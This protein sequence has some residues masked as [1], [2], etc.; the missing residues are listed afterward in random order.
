MRNAL[1]RVDLFFAH[2]PEARRLVLELGLPVDRLRNGVAPIAGLEARPRAGLPAPRIVFAGRLHPEKGPDLLIR[3]LA[4]MERPPPTLM[5]GSGDMEDELRR[6]VGNAGLGRV[7]RFMGWRPDPAPFIAGASAVAVPS[8]H[9]AWSQVA[10]TAM[11][12]GVP[13][14][15]F[16]VEGLPIT[17]GSGRGMLVPPADPAALA[18]ALEDVVAGRRSVDRGDARAYAFRFSP[19]RVASVYGSAYRALA[20]REALAATSAA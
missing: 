7:V 16:A 3:A 1:R 2:G 5:L 18:E 20:A 12:L 9:E 8:R 13:V 19:S 17:L 10:V 4:A 11:G 15:G 6:A 14:V